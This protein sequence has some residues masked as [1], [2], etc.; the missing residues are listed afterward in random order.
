MGISTHVPFA[1]TVDQTFFAPKSVP[2]KSWIHLAVVFSESE[3]RIYLD[4]EQQL[5]GPPTKPHG[6]V[7]FVV[8][9]IGL[10]NPLC[11]FNGQVRS[12]R[13]SRGEQYTA[14]FTPGEDMTANEATE[15]LYTIKSIDGELVKDLSGKGN[16]GKV[17]RID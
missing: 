12:V 9:N 15:L 5:I 17:E 1:E 4:G 3:T 13:I 14:D 7:V 16:D 6:D 10:D 8:G 2:I 11:Y